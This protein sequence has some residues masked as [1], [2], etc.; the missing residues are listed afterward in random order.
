MLMFAAGSSCA[1]LRTVRLRL[2]RA[3]MARN[4]PRGD[5]LAPAIKLAGFLVLLAAIFAGAHAA[6]SPARAGDH[7]ALAGP[8]HRRR[9]GGNRDEHG[10]A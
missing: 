7:R 8:V 6:G 9:S 1:L 5:P 10:R 2:F 4:C 3:S